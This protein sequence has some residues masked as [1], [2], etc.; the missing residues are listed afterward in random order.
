[1][2]IYVKTTDGVASVQLQSL[3]YVELNSTRDTLERTTN[4]LNKEEVVYSVTMVISDPPKGWT[5]YDTKVPTRNGP[6]EIW[7]DTANTFVRQANRSAI[8]PI[9][10]VDPSNWAN[11]ICCKLE[12]FGE[13]LIV[14]T[15][16]NSWK[17]YDV[18]VTIKF[19]TR[20]VFQD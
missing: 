10:Y 5:Y 14:I 3:R 1:M 15:G 12:S 18:V 7:I 11:T 6:R 8:Y 20:C 9:P 17:G 19:T 13:K 16:E 4:I 2:S